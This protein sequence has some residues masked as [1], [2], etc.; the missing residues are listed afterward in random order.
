MGKKPYILNA[1][2]SFCLEGRLGDIH[3]A[4]GFWKLVAYNKTKVAEQ[5]T[6]QGAS[7]VSSAV[8]LEI[9]IAL[10]TQWLSHL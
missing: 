1:K 3:K 2:S 9:Q 10:L 5:P 8:M 7:Q 6:A 4:L